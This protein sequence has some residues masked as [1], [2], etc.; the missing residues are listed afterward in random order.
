MICGQSKAG[1]G[2]SK[3]C[4]GVVFGVYFINTIGGVCAALKAEGDFAETGK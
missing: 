3:G 1:A 2:K 4:L